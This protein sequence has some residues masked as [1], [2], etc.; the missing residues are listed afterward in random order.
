MVFGG[1]GGFGSSRG[2]AGQN[3]L[4]AG[5]LSGQGRNGRMNGV[6]GRA[7]IAQFLSTGA[8]NA[9][10]AAG[11]AGQ[12]HAAAYRSAGLNVDGTEI[13]P[14]PTQSTSNKRCIRKTGRREEK[15][16]APLDVVE[17][18]LRLRKTGVSPGPKSVWSSLRDLVT[19]KK[20]LKNNFSF[21]MKSIRDQRGLMAIPLRH[22]G[23]FGFEDPK[24]SI[25]AQSRETHPD[26]TGSGGDGFGEYSTMVR[27]PVQSMPSWAEPVLGPNNVIR[28][29]YRLCP[30]WHRLD[31]SSNHS[32][33]LT[34]PVTTGA[35]TIW[36]RLTRLCTNRPFGIF[37]T[38]ITIMSKR[39]SHQ[40]TL[41]AD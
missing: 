12:S 22:D 24:W 10:L 40:T 8:I 39:N 1:F 13:D 19:G 3:A 25:G 20:V 26:G 23:N 28:T 14:K 29:K 17:R 41:I 27:T 35:S 38:K 37:K 5:L 30:T 31:R 9:G 7:A 18:P 4:A 21:K 2:V 15:I 36:V 16:A 34:K 11:I 6:M 32:G 33:I